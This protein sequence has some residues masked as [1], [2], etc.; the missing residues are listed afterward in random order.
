ME[1][2]DPKLVFGTLLFRIPMIYQYLTGDM[3]ATAKKNG[4]FF[5]ISN[6]QG[7]WKERIGSLF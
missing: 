3:I 6:V 2:F 1:Q 7:R 4:R 5:L